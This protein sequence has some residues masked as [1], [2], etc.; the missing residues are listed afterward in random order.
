M[1]TVAASLGVT[2][3]QVAQAWLLHR[4][5]NILLIAGT[6]RR[7]HLRENLS[8]AKLQLGP[9]VIAQLDSISV[10]AKEVV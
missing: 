10:A 9:E 7:T 4:S 1:D 5:P 2:P 8:V 3:M 6:S